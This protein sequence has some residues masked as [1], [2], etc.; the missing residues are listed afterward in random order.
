MK[1]KKIN[2]KIFFYLSYNQDFVIFLYPYIKDICYYIIYH[3]ILYYI[4]F[5]L[6]YLLYYVIN[7]YTL[8]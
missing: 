3:I 5:Y 8:Y 4:M 7:T 2:Y 6:L 1:Q